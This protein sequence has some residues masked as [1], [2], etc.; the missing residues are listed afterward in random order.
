MPST[1][2]SVMGTA[3]HKSTGVYD[4]SRLLS[5]AARHLS[6]DDA[7]EAL[8]QHLRDP[9]E[10]VNWDGMNINKACTIALGA[11]T[12]YCTEVAPNYKYLAVEE[13]LNELLIDFDDLGVTIQLSGTLDRLYLKDDLLGVADIKTGATACSQS[14]GK[15]KAQLGAYELL[16]EQKLGT[17]CAQPGLLLQLQTSSNY[18]V[19][20]TE[21][22]NAKRALLGDADNTGL[23]THLAR[24]LSLG[25]FWGNPSSWLCGEKYCPVW[26]DCIYR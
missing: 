25:D 14:S 13:P 9:G 6:A 20:V 26:A 7:A 8:M 4:A 23:L 17:I 21:V 19:G 18:K 2:P 1:P 22:V 5:N 15:H 24:A 16:A 11:H 10:E 12:R 3:I